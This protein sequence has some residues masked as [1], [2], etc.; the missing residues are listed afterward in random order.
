MRVAGTVAPVG[1][2]AYDIR[3]RAM[4]IS[5][6]CSCGKKMSAKEEFAGRRLRCPE[7]QRVVTIPKAGPALMP[8]SPGKSAPPS[9][10]ILVQPNLA[11]SDVVPLDVTRPTT[12]ETPPPSKPVSFASPEN[13]EALFAPSMARTPVLAPPPNAPTALLAG[14]PSNAELGVTPIVAPAG[15]ATG[16]RSAEPPSPT[17]HPWVDQSL[18]QIATPWRPGDEARF[19]AGI[20][21]AR[22]SESPL[23]WIMPILIVAATIFF[24][25]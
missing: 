5:F 8:A 10:R 4:P 25:V 12:Q 11:K 14:T 15:E 19:Q 24:A 13:L 21:P 6:E 17:D 18:R 1:D 23:L 2:R 20:A 3:E 7:C 9:G 16:A 22:E